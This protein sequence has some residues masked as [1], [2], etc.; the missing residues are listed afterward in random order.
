M[1]QLAIIVMIICILLFLSWLSL[2]TFIAAKHASE[3]EYVCPKC[4]K[5]FSPRKRDSLGAAI[6]FGHKSVLVRCRYCENKAR[7]LPTDEPNHHHDY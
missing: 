3:K 4:G 7:L 6:S 1:S 2:A 5:T